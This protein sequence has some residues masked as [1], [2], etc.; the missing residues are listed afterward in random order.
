MIPNDITSVPIDHSDLPLEVHSL[1][2]GSSRLLRSREIAMLLFPVV[3]S[4]C[5]YRW[6]FPDVSLLSDRA[7]ITAVARRKWVPGLDQDLFIDRNDSGAKS[8]WFFR[9]REKRYHATVRPQGAHKPRELTATGTYSPVRRGWSLCT[10]PIRV[11]FSLPHSISLIRSN[12]TGTHYI[13][14]DR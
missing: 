14:F 4:T 7:I 8:K 12:A 9:E 1:R 13:P 11:S 3:C 10:L 5:R 6:F 2:T